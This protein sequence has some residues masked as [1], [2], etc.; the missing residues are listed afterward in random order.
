M[1]ILKPLEAQGC[2][3]Q[4][5]L[6]ESDLP[7]FKQRMSKNQACLKETGAE[8]LQLDQGWNVL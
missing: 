5:F 7:W 1:A 2:I 8:N 3:T 4:N 6:E